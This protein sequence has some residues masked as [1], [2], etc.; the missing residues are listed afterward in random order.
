MVDLERRYA[1]VNATYCEMF[2][3]TAGIVGQRVVDVLDAQYEHQIR[4]YLNRALAGERVTFEARRRTPTGTRNFTVSYEPTK[5]DAA[6]VMVVV[7][8]TD[9]TELKQSEQALAESE[10]RFR[11]MMEN[12]ELISMTLDR[13]GVVTF[14]N[15]YLLRLTGWDRDDVIGHDWFDRFIPA[16]DHAVKKLF[17]EHIQRETVP[18]HHENPIKTRAGDLQD[19]AWNNTVLRDSNGAVVGTASIGEDVTARKLAEQ[20]IREQLDELLRWQEVML[21]RE[22]RVIL[23]KTEVNDVLGRQGQP[24]RYEVPIDS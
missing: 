10:H 12:L 21:N 18:P 6:V 14:C 1:F 13:S 9:V 3:V 11:E 17:L 7:V 16:E 24:P 20:K 8:V 5:R 22:D 19:I 23:L 2:G 15:D 4:P